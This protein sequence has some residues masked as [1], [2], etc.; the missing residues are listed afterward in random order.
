MLF[1]RLQTPDPVLGSR[2]GFWRSCNQVAL[3]WRCL[4]GFYEEVCGGSIGITSYSNVIAAS[5]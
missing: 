3:L 2:Y 4:I 1:G 5:P